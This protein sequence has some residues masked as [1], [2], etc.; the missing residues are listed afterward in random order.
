[1]AVP[2]PAENVDAWRAWTG[3]LK[4]ARKAEF[5]A[6]NARHNVTM[7]DGWLQA[8]PDGSYLV[9]VIQEGDGAAGYLGSMAQSDDAFDQWFLGQ[10]ASLHGM[11]PSAGPPPMAVR[12]L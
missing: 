7:H 5:D 9:I 4:G 12:T 6:S 8:N 11:D 2:L 1:M 10:V 3:E